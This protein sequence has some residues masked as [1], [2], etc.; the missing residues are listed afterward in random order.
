MDYVTTGDVARA[1]GVSLNTVKGWIR[2]GDMEAVR[3]PSG[4]FRIPRRELDR[5]LQGR[6]W[7]AYESWERG[8]PVE[9]PEVDEVLEW[10]DAVLRLAPAGGRLVP[11]DPLDT[12]RHVRRVHRALAPLCR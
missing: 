10:I 8:R 7:A 4:H 2:T 12:A 9:G 11:P 3:L 6:R 1:L 5:I